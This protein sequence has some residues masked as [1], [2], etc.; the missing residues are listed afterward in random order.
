MKANQSMAQWL[1]ESESK[2][3]KKTQGNVGQQ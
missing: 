2:L 1:S 3:A